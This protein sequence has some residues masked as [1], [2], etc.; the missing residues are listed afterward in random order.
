MIKLLEVDYL[1][2]LGEGRQSKINYLAMHAF[3][4][5]YCKKCERVTYAG[6]TL[7]MTEEH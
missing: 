4:G 3:N 6:E 1:E 2:G 5:V 7:I